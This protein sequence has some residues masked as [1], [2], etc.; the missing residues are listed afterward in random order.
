[1]KK[2]SLLLIAGI[3][4]CS[5]Q[6]C[7]PGFHDDMYL[8]NELSNPVLCIY[9]SD[10][11]TLNPNEEKMFFHMGG[12]GHSIFDNYYDDVFYFFPIKIVFNDSLS[13]SY[14]AENIALFEKTTLKKSS[15]EVV[16]HE[17]SSR[18]SS[19]KAVYTIDEEDYH[20]ALVQCG[21]EQEGIDYLGL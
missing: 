6:S 19:L 11:T 10:T 1:M 9:M 5:L 21:Y 8:T 20:N 3:M 18:N 12:I 7:D 15:W 2:T 4:A 16:E 13:I 14:E 17:G